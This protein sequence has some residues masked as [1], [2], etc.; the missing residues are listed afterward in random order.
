MT[1][2][3]QGPLHKK[4]TTAGQPSEQALQKDNEDFD[5]AVHKDDYQDIL[6][7]EDCMLS[8]LD[9]LLGNDE[10]PKKKR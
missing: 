4:P 9:K 3:E 10:K 7:T 2:S 6:S 8:A 1:K 5:R